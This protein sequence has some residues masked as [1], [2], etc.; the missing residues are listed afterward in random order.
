M[1]DGVHVTFRTDK[2]ERIRQRLGMF[3]FDA[4][5]KNNFLCVRE[6]WIRGDLYRHDADIVGF[7][8]GLRRKIRNT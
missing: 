4:P 7:V 2:G 3:D 8:N 1:R 6:L 5:E